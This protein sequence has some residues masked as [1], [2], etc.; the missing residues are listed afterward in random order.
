V[1]RRSAE[2]AAGAFVGALLLVALIEA[3]RQETGAL[4]VVIGIAL[5]VLGGLALS[6]LRTPR[7]V[8]RQDLVVWLTRTSGITGETPEELANRAVSAYRAD[9]GDDARR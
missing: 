1:S 3:V 8:L 6:Q 2:A 9:L 5:V 4:A 7:L